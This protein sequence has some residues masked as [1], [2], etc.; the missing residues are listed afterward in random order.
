MIAAPRC[1]TLLIKSVPSHVLS[2]IVSLTG[3]PRMSAWKKSGKR[4]MISPD[5][6]LRYVMPVEAGL[7]SQLDLCAVFIQSRHGK[8]A[9]EGTSFAFFIAIRQLVLQG[10]PT[11][12]TRTSE[13]A[14]RAIA[15]PCE[16]KIFP[17][18]PRRS[19]RSIP[20]LRG[21]LPT[22]NAQFTPRKPRR[23]PPWQRL[24]AE[25]ETHSPGVP[26]QRL[27]APGARPEFSMRWRSTG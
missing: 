17:L 14:F 15:S 16:V 1:W 12:T 25:G 26:S 20:A 10:F 13:A 11:T 21:T 24:F 6:Q 8:P 27:P 9:V 2:V 23:D 18:I 22:R 5:S 7:Q 3:L 4:T 19:L